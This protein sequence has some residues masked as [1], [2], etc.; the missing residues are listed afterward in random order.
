MRWRFFGFVLTLALNHTL[1][2]A[3]GLYQSIHSLALRAC[4]KPY[5]RWRFGLVILV[6]GGI[7]M[8]KAFSLP[9]RREVGR[10]DSSQN[11][12]TACV[13]VDRVAFEPIQLLA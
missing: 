1:A 2:G 11:L 10:Q 7:W 8:H 4:I 6:A 9:C 12:L 3:S 13:G 5:T